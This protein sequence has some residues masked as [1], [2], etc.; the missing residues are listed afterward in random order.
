MSGAPPIKH[1]PLQDPWKEAVPSESPGVLQLRKILT[2]KA[3]EVNI[4][5]TFI[6]K[7]AITQDILN[8]NAKV[9]PLGRHR[10][11]PWSTRGSC[12]TQK[13]TTRGKEYIGKA[14]ELLKVNRVNSEF[15]ELLVAAGGMIDDRQYQCECLARKKNRLILENEALGRITADELTSSRAG[16]WHQNFSSQLGKKRTRYPGTQPHI[17]AGRALTSHKLAKE[18]NAHLL[19]TVGANVFTLLATKK[20]IGQFHPYTRYEN[21]TSSCCNHCQG[22]LIVLYLFMF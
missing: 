3:V 22:E 16:S 21:T 10:G 13:G 14:A 5:R 17:T 1:D 7:A 18:V 9:R 6:P 8:K 11:L 19:G 2:E 20:N 15:Q 4:V 12:R